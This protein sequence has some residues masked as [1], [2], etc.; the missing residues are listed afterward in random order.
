MDDA[1]CLPDELRQIHY[2]IR[3]TYSFIIFHPEDLTEVGISSR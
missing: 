2:V 3:M 1:L